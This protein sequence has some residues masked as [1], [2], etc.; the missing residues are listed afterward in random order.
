MPKI[1]DDYIKKIVKSKINIPE[2]YVNAINTAFTK[3]K[4]QK[5]NMMKILTTVCASLFLTTSVVFAGYSIYERV[6][7]EPIKETYEEQEQN[8]LK[9]IS[10]EEKIGLITEE[11]AINKVKELIEKLGY[12][13][14]EIID[15]NLVR[16][17]EKNN[18]FYY[19]VTTNST[20]NH[21]CIFSIEAST[22]ELNKFMDNKLKYKNIESDDLSENEIINIANNIYKKMGI[23]IDDYEVLKIE[24]NKHYFESYINDLWTVSYGKKYDGVADY[25]DMFQ[26]TFAINDGK[27]EI[28][29]LSTGLEN[30]FQ[31][32]DIEITEEEAIEIA[33]NK[34]K[35]FS[36]LEISKT[37][38]E[39]GIE[40]MNLFI[41]GLE[42]FAENKNEYKIDDISRRVWIVRIEHKKEGKSKDYSWEGIR[43]EWNKKYYVDATTG[44]I[45]G[46]DEIE[47]MNE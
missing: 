24:K 36:N 26:V 9:E 2:G 27:V 46:G 17:Y 40:K 7:K 4:N 43:K 25:S 23:K 20:E 14:L 42:N 15:V 39:L 18:I 16:D 30:L 37:T 29:S 44:E 45:I 19:E 38:A 31:N 11:E 35:E 21:E 22:G 6:W 8:A 34:E 10:E 1:N 5:W 32:N 33:E 41:Y 3:E 47:F 12:K 13:E 28:E